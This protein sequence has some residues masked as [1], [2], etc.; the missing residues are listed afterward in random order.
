MRQDIEGDFSYVKRSKI[1][2]YED[3]ESLANEV[4]FLPQKLQNGSDNIFLSFSE[5]A[6]LEPAIKSL[7]I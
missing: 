5:A 2:L 7:K 1:V 4:S 3:A 6:D